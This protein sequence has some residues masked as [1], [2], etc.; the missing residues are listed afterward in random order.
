MKFTSSVPKAT[1]PIPVALKPAPA[2]RQPYSSKWDGGRS[3]A[4]RVLVVP[5]VMSPMRTPRLLLGF[6]RVPMA[7]SYNADGL[8]MPFPPVGLPLVSL[9]S[10]LLTCFDEYHRS[11]PLHPR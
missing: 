6:S 5:S 10:V 7:A 4:S 2:K 9:V 11:V 1:S 8:R 3:P